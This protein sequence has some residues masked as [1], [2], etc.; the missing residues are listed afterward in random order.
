MAETP[1]YRS[2]RSE[3][4]KSQKSG[5][6]QLQNDSSLDLE[7]KVSSASSSPPPTRA[8]KIKGPPRPPHPRGESPRSPAE[9]QEDLLID[10]SED[11]RDTP[12]PVSSV[13]VCDD[14]HPSSN[15]LYTLSACA[16]G[17]PVCAF[18]WCIF[19]QRA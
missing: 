4:K 1:F 15:E 11:N 14:S 12:S 16:T 10:L 2:F 6:K 13:R 19:K 3:N 5:Y 18:H 8:S 9:V 17:F 7:R